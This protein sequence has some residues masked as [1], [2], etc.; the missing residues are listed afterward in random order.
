[1]YQRQ[2]KYAEAEHL[3]LQALEI[4]KKHLGEKHP[5]VANSLNGL[6]GL[7]Q[8]Q[9]KYTEAEH[10][11]LQALEIVEK[12]LGKDHPNTQI[13]RENYKRLKERS[14]TRGQLIQVMI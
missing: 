13:V 14:I 1:M 7:Y 3:Y 12:A 2:G 6:A 5:D 10:L 11:Y 4:G 9:R 8:K